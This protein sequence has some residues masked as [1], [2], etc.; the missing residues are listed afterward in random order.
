MRRNPTTFKMNA[1][2]LFALIGGVVAFVLTGAIVET[3]L[4]LAGVLVGAGVGWVVRRFARRAA[5]FEEAVDLRETA[6]RE[7]LYER[8][9]ELE[10]GGRS[11]MTKDQLVVAITEAESQSA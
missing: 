3:L 11:G 6:T 8:A 4:V 1:I 2:S 9:K 5:A 10:I 7:Q